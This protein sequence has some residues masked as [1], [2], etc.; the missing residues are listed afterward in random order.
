MF[1]PRHQFIQHRH[2]GLLVAASRRDFLDEP[3]PVAVLGNP[4][5]RFGLDPLRTIFA[6]GHFGRSFLAA[7]VGPLGNR[8]ALAGDNL[9][10][11]RHRPGDDF[12]D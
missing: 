11:S 6:G 10:V 5:A 1:G 2:R 8:F 12:F 3:F 4:L 7:S 9:C